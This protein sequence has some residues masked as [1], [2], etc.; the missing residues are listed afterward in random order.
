MPDQL[1][2]PSHRLQTPVSRRRHRNSGSFMAFLGSIDVLTIKV[3]LI[4]DKWTMFE[5]NSYLCLTLYSY[6]IIIVH[7]LYE[8]FCANSCKDL[9]SSMHKAI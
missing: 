2:E 9:V 5:D 4:A 3:A 7:H 8:L 6:C 1:P